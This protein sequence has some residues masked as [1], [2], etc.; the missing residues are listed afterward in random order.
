MGRYM[1]SLSMLL[2]LDVEWLA[3]GHGFLIGEPRDA[4]E[5]LILH[6][7]TR[8]AKVL[9]ALAAGHEDLDDLLVQVYDDVPA[10]LHPVARRSLLA[11]LLHLRASGR[12]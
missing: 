2:T 12:G 9:R 1:D 10:A 4:I 5:R 8:E 3:P 6:R 7:R 11:H